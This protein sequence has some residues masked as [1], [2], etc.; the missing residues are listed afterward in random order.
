MAVRD[1][2]ALGAVLAC[3]L[4]GQASAACDTS[5]PSE[6]IPDTR[7]QLSGGQAY[8]STTDLTWE[9]CS[10]G[11]RWTEGRGCTG[12]AARL[13]WKQAT[14]RGADGWR[15]PTHAELGTLVAK[16]CSPTINPTVFPGMDPSSPW[17]WS[18]T[19]VEA[20]TAWVVSFSGAPP[21]GSERKGRFPVRLV[22]TGK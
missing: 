22:K 11:Q 1:F 16:G 4:G 19:S 18:S 9:R 8:D 2:V 3:A 10:V 21:Y 5:R 6:L 15:L 20:E 12:K 7:Y 13:N 17:Y 14:E